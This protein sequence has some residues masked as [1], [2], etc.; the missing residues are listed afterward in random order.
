MLHPYA[1]DSD[2]RRR[3]PLY[4]AGLAIASAIGVSWVL[5]RV[6]LPG[7][8]D[9]PATAGFYGLYYEAFRRR[10]WRIQTLQKWKW[11]KVPN[12]AGTWRGHVVTSFDDRAGKHSIEAEIVQDWTHISVKMRSDYSRSESL[13]GSIFVGD[14]IV[15]DYEY[16]NEPLPDAAETMHAHRGTASL[17]LSPDGRTLSGDYYSGRDRQNF[18]ALF[19]QRV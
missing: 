1:T 11:V 15:L 13:V 7:W 18:G 8:L 12:L 10:I 5:Q 16:R 17:I 14:D 2:E 9:V 3:I 19:L 6:H 4:L